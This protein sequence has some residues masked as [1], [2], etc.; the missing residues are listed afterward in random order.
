[1]IVTIDG[2]AGAG[3][4]TIARAVAAKLGYV[5]LDTGA[6]YRAIAWKALVTGTDMTDPAAMTRL[7]QQTR[8][9]ILHTPDGGMAVSVDGKPLGDEIRTPEVTRAAAQVAALP[10]VRKW[11]LPRQQAF[12]RRPDVAGVVAEGRDLGTKI[13]PEA[14]AKFFFRA[15]AAERARRRHAEL[16]AA[17]KVLDLAETRSALDARDDRDQSREIAPLTAAEDAVVIDTTRL[18]V[19]EVVSHL[20]KVIEAKAAHRR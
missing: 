4:S 1:M 20:L 12:G 13:F 8:L 2:P 19:D 16:L 7:C 6:L 10:E 3:K 17:G 18:S 5:Y 9:E 14:P 11:L 15:D